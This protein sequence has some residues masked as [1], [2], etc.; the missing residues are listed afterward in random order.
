ELAKTVQAVRADDQLMSP[1]QHM[2]L[3]RARR[4][5]AVALAV[6]D[7]FAKASDLET[8]Q[9]RNAHAP[10]QGEEAAAY[11]RLLSASAYVAAFTFAAYLLQTLESDAEAPNDIAEPHFVFDTQQ[12]AI[13]SLIAGL[14]AALAGARD[15]ADLA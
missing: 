4:G 14:D 10:L 11:K 8:L 6:G 15:D 12:D 2:L 5:I 3:Y 13:K 9:S 7:L 1:A